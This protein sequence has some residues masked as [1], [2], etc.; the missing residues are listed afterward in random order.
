V[1]EN[2]ELAVREQA[3]TK[4][5]GQYRALNMRLLQEL[6]MAFQFCA[7]QMM[8][9]TQQ[10]AANGTT[11]S[12]QLFMFLP[13]FEFMD[14]VK[15]FHTDMNNIYS[16]LTNDELA[17][18]KTTPANPMDAWKT[19]N[20]R[21]EM[22]AALERNQRLQ[23][24][25]EFLTNSLT[26][27]GQFESEIAGVG[28]IGG[29]PQPE[30]RRKVTNTS[31][32]SDF[33]ITDLNGSP[34]EDPMLMSRVAPVRTV[35]E[36]L[37]ALERENF[38][39]KA[40]LESAMNDIKSHSGR[41]GS[42]SES[43]ETSASGSSTSRNSLIT[44]SLSL[45]PAVPDNSPLRLE[46]DQLR[47]D[48]LA[49]EKDLAEMKM[50]LER[51][52]KENQLQLQRDSMTPPRVPSSPVNHSAIG[53]S[54]SQ[55]S[56]GSGGGSDFLN[57][58]YMDV[59]KAKVALEE[60]VKRL[61]Q[62]LAAAQDENSRLQE[63][64]KLSMEKESHA[65]T[66]SSDEGM[67]E[68]KIVEL[69]SD[70]EESPVTASAT[71]SS[72]DGDSAHRVEL[73]LQI[74][75]LQQVIEEKSSQLK[76]QEQELQF[77]KQH[78]KEKA[79]AAADM[80]TA[81]ADIEKELG[82]TKQALT[83]AEKKITA[84][85]IKIETLQV[86]HRQQQRESEEKHAVAIKS[87]SIKDDDVSELTKQL[88]LARQEV[89]QLRYRSNNLESVHEKLEDAL[90]EKKSMQ[91]KLTAL[92]GQ[93]Y[94]QRSR[95]I[96]GNSMTPDGVKD[97]ALIEELH[98]Q[99]DQKSAQLMIA[100][101]DIESMRRELISG[102]QTTAASAT[103][104]SVAA[105][106]SSSKSSA[107]IADLEAK[108]AKFSFDIDR[109]CERNEDQARRINALSERV[110]KTT[111]E[112]YE[113]EGIMKEMLREMDGIAPP[114][115]SRSPE[116]SSVSEVA[117]EVE[118]YEELEEKAP[119]PIPVRNS[120]NK[121]MER[122]ASALKTTFERRGSAPRAPAPTPSSPRT[123][124]SSKVAHLIK[125]FSSEEASGDSDPA[126]KRRG[127]FTN[128][129]KKITKIDFRHRQGSEPRSEPRDD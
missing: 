39:L 17:A 95:T 21:E 109:L 73:E 66:R 43:A 102:P 121:A 4:N 35:T 76:V 1:F 7:Q 104:E 110:E 78:L 55:V 8:Q 123:S 38:L 129:I 85:E 22:D 111:R 105:A 98:R 69:H 99:L 67:D 41:G 94:E 27:E 100:Q 11:P 15:K 90:K 44:A 128:S 54:S 18:G 63:Q 106:A 82:T 51:V 60:K 101:R 36:Q 61:N 45:L 119:A 80:E 23:Q 42:P 114:S 83:K 52:R 9:I 118:E 91:V 13:Q 64:L 112:K 97:S 92:E 68:P 40:K 31:T 86:D 24:Q 65:G 10:A 81:K 88:K 62:E 26:F 29:L 74:Q 124:S 84:L 72:T 19:F 34:H 2:E 116:A 46:V 6:E 16:G 93:L 122:Y 49:L 14:R 3:E 113:L 50:E 103:A 125:N 115:P 75:Q 12:P 33:S 96:S 48:K 53:M 32:A 79:T 58:I 71:G 30:M 47:D 5:A 108:V 37:N 117:Y 107:D 126:A 70:D 127:T 56:S 57:K 87:P 77:M 20:L 120:G 59:G 28:G 25:L 89:M